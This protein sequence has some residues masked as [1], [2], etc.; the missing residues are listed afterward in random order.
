MNVSETK[1]PTGIIWNYSDELVVANFKGSKPIMTASVEIS[2]IPTES[3]LLKSFKHQKK[4][5]EQNTRIGF[6]SKQY[7][8]TTNPYWW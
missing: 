5:N 8:Q 7:F 4:M 1:S 3:G 6:V 2:T